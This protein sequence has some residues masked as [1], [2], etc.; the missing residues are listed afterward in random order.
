MIS[1]NT[2]WLHSVTKA[3][4][5]LFHDHLIPCA[6]LWEVGID[7]ARAV[8]HTDFESIAGVSSLR[9]I[10][11]VRLTRD[12]AR[13]GDRKGTAKATCSPLRPSNEINES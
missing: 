5:F 11:I 12:S 1:N 9:A 7:I 13:K 8:G 10:R 6:S 2:G 3:S 4:K